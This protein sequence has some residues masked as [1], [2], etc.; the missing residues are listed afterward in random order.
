MGQPNHQKYRVTPMQYGTDQAGFNLTDRRFLLF[1]LTVMAIWITSL[2]A[3]RAAEPTR[4]MLFGDSLLAGYGLSD[5]DS[6]ANQLDAALTEKGQDVTII[7][8]SVSG[9]TTAG[10]VSRLSWSLADNPDLVILALGGNDILRAID[11]ANTR[12][13]MTAML[14]TFQ[15]EQV[16]VL[17]AG[18]IA[19]KSLGPEYA[20]A[21]DAIYPELADQYALGYYPFLLDGVAGNQALNQDDGI[22]PNGKGVAVM[23]SGMLPVILET[24]TKLPTQSG[25]DRAK[26]DG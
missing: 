24:L 21:F 1:L 22:H 15:R 23:V 26:T 3:V 8:A 11:P 6:F 12:E 18:M 16:P 17:V 10:G 4:I 25:S 2:S 7:N 20:A 9:D 13:N 5:A 19:P 14:A